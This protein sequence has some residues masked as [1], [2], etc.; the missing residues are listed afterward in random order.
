MPRGLLLLA[1]TGFPPLLLTS[2]CSSALVWDPPRAP[3]P[4]GVSLPQC[5]GCISSH[6]PSNV[7]FHTAPPLLLPFS[8]S[9]SIHGFLHVCPFLCLSVCPLTC[10]HL[11]LLTHVSSHPGQAPVP[12]G[13]PVFNGTELRSM[14]SSDWLRLWWAVQSQLEPAA[15]GTGRFMASSHTGHPTTK[16]HCWCPI[17]SVM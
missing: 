17:N 16:P 12:R 9:R 4:S 13:T 8:P 1:L 2:Y 6:D 10:L 14:R 15:A 5:G 11:H 3:I 7:P